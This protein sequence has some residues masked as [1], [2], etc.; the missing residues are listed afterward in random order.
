MPSCSLV[1][2]ASHHTPKLSLPESN[3]VHPSNLAISA[4][5]SVSFIQIK[6]RLSLVFGLS[7]LQQ[8][9]RL[10]LARA[11]ILRATHSSTVPFYRHVAIRRRVEF[12]LCR[13]RPCIASAGTVGFWTTF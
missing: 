8:L 10:Q 4:F 13:H 7:E 11:L 2:C 1:A 9:H 6:Q 12:W 5:W 3:S